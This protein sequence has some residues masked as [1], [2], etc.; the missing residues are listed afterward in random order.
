MNK[1]IGKI[2]TKISKILDLGYKEELPIF[3]GEANIKHMKEEHPEDYKKYEKDIEDI[4]KKPTYLARN[5][6]KKS[7]EFIK[8]YKID[9][10]FVLIAVIVSNNNVHFARTMYVMADEKVKKYFKHKY[11]YK[12]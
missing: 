7:I 11:F 5:E 10:D 2:T 6:K 1:Q 4:I 12:F 8:E 3:I 9:N